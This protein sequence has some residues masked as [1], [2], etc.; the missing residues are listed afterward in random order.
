M[1]NK[2]Y[3]EQINRFVKE[4]E[5]KVTKIQKEKG[6]DYV[7]ITCKEGHHFKK[8]K[9]KLLRDKQ[10]C[11]YY[12]CNTK[13]SYWKDEQGFKIFKTRLKEIFGDDVICIEKTPL[14]STKFLFQCGICGS[15]WSNTPSY[16]LTPKKNREKPPSC[17]KCGGSSALTNTEKQKHLNQLNIKPIE[18][19]ESIK[20]MHTFFHYE[21]KKCLSKYKK[22]LNQLVELRK[23]NLGYCDCSYKRKHWTLLDLKQEGSK[24]GYQLLGNPKKV[25][26]STLYKWKCQKKGHITKFTIG[27]LKNGC[28]TCYNDERFTNL[29]DIKDWL[30]DN[31]PLIKLVPKQSWKGAN[32]YYE[33]KCSRCKQPFTKHLHNLIKYPSCQS[34]G[35]ARYSEKI[36][37]LYL[38]RL[39]GINFI[40]NKKYDFLKNSNGN[41]MELDGYNSEHK[42]AFEHHGIQHYRKTSLHNAKNTLNKRLKDDELKRKQCVS[43]GIKL[44]EIPALFQMTPINELREV[45]KEKL[46]E[47]EINIP[48]DFDKIKIDRGELNICIKSKN[49]Y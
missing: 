19:I 47:L 22:T 9:G 4:K 3:A 45:I 40:I 46:I 16:Q 44:I 2:N 24:N 10:Y 20:N 27:S 21:C 29:N 48:D 25:D 1:Q 35:H 7:Y 11:K 13:Y 37:K 18:G 5:G 43:E 34:K 41:K 30:K 28:S 32:T 39:L 26:T 12:P 8:E 38:E 23:G 36:V 49:T 42:I 14:K 6:K 31:A 33:F 15:K 17:K